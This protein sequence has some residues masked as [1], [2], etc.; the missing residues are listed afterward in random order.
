MRILSVIE[1]IWPPTV[2]NTG[3][4]A[5]YSLQKEISKYPNVELHILTFVEK[6]ADTEWKSWMNLESKKYGIIFHPVENKI[7]NKAPKIYFYYMKIVV[8]IYEIY[9]AKKYNFDIIV[10]Y[11]SAPL[12]IKRMALL[13]YFIHSKLVHYLCVNNL[14]QSDK[15]YHLDGKVDLILCSTEKQKDILNHVNNVQL[16]PISIDSQRFLMKNQTEKISLYESR[17]ERYDKKRILY[18]G[19]I[20]KRKGICVFL[21]SCKDI[22]NKRND[23]L[24]IIATRKQSGNFY[25]YDNNKNKILKTINDL[26]KENFLFLDGDQDVPS[27]IHASDLVVLPLI[28]L[29]GITGYPVTMLEAMVCKKIVIMPRFPEIMEVIEDGYNGIL[30]E[31]NN[32][33]DLSTKIILA[34]DAENKF[35]IGQNARKSIEKYE[36]KKI[37]C[38]FICALKNIK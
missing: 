9:F 25:D 16:L 17:L 34:L 32:H 29:H 22:L 10:E 19:L 21:K 36:L 31:C 33:K 2:K 8:F 14:G 37:A 15:S 24:F 4:S 7:L 13:K 27:L 23:V 3:I 12:L 28:S 11:S 6:W 5:L 18:L 26:G 30:F 1:G 35:E 38:D 20:E